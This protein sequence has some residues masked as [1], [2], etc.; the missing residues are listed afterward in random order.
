MQFYYIMIFII[1]CVNLPLSF[2]LTCAYCFYTMLLYH[3][4]L[5]FYTVTSHYSLTQLAIWFPRK[6]AFLNP[7]RAYRRRDVS[8]IDGGFA[9]LAPV[10]AAA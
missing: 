4:I 10:D 8:R 3:Y 7:R 6:S 5:H 2:Y 9:A 1:L